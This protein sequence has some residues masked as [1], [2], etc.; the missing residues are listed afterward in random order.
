MKNMSKVFPSESSEK[1]MTWQAPRFENEQGGQRAGNIG[2]RN[3]ETREQLEQTR[4]RVHEQAFAKGYAEGLEKCKQEM[5]EQAAYL[6]SL[7]KALASPLRNLDKHVV[8]DLVQLCMA[9]MRQLVRRELKTSPDEVIPVVREALN[10][11]PDSAGE[12]RLEL[13]PE[14]AVLVRKILGGAEAEAPWR[15]IEDPMLSRGGCKVSTS[16]SRIDATVEN[17]INMAIAAVIGG[18]RHV[19]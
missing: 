4:R 17:R 16:V 13:H 11:L 1:C 18:D 10:Q 5:C 15:I 6:E 3:V 8:D 9:V 7:M 14:D 2:A 12:I 19:D